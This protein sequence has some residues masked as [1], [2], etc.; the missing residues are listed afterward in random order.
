MADEAERLL[1]ETTLRVAITGLSRSGKTVF[2]TSVIANLL[3]MGR[4]RNTLPALSAQLERQGTRLLSVG[5]EPAGTQALDWFDAADKI[6]DLAGAQPHWPPRTSDLA[7]ASLTLELSRSGPARLL[8]P[9]RVRLDLLDYPGEW[10]LDLPLL[11]Q[12]F[13]S[14][15]A[16]TLALLRA[17]PRA[18]VAGEFLDFIATLDPAAPADEAVARRGHRLYLTVLEQARDRFGLRWL[19]PGRFLRPGPRGESPMM[20]FFPLPG[21]GP[22]PARSLRD[23]LARRFAAYRDDMRQNFFDPWFAR[24]DRQVVLVDVLGALWAGEGAF[25]DTRHAIAQVAAAYDARSRSRW[26]GISSLKRVGFVA[27]KTDHVPASQRPALES[28]FSSMIATPGHD[29]RATSHRALAALRCTEDAVHD[30]LPVVLGVPLGEERRRP[31]RPGH[32][33]SAPP[34]PGDAFWSRPFF[35]LPV[36]RPPLID[37]DGRDGLPHLGLDELLAWLLEDAL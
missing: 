35:E 20:W 11:D 13:S 25:E 5:L 6:R 14:W 34:P 16:E 4:G 31:F 1:N 18:E 36:F 21:E 8:G 10:L 15:S 9:R 3:A 33:P 24:F 32:I 22:A 28:L 17:R 26:F 7:S 30:G 12:D 19:Q 37:P 23:L 2:I 29:R 27:S